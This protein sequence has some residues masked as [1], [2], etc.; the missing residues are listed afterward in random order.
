MGSPTPEITNAPAV[1][2]PE[3]GETSGKTMSPPGLTLMAGAPAAPPGGPDYNALAQQMKDELDEYFPDI[4]DVNAILEKVDWRNGWQQLSTAYNLVNPTKPLVL[5]MKERLSAANYNNAMERVTGISVENANGSVG[6]RTAEAGYNLRADA[7]ATSK[8]IG[9]MNFTAMNVKVRGKGIDGDTTFYKVVFNDTDYAAVTAGY[10]TAKLAPDLA[11]EKAAWVTG[12][13]LG[14]YVSWDALITQLEHFDIMTVGMDIKAKITML[15]QM[16]HGGDLPFDQVIGTSSGSYYEDDR[17][18][19]TSFYQLL[20]EG[21]AVKTP[22]GEVID[23]YHFI[24][25]LD[26]YQSARRRDKTPYSTAGGLLE[27]NP[28]IGASDAAATWAGDIG[29]GAADCL[30]SQSAEY[31]KY[32]TDN[33][34]GSESERIDYYYRSRAPESDLLGDIDAWGAYEE[35]DNGTAVTVTEVVRNY[36]GAQKAGGGA[37]KAKRKKSLDG[38]FARYGLKPVGGTYVTE[39]NLQ[40][41]FENIKRFAVIWLQMRTG[42]SF[43]FKN[44]DLNKFATYTTEMSMKFLL[45]IQAQYEKNK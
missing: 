29:A 7:K 43:A 17:P 26:A 23:I 24:V 1:A 20:K 12:D 18:N 27:M 8:Q 19:L 44:F 5:H 34:K 39:A 10:D 9:K 3:S 11:S 16:A 35:V 41:L 33:K 32:L 45:F 2:A 21:K 38:F 4:A 6:A 30:L 25:G 40:I 14:I 22:N 42:L 13:A 15:R 28:D 36:Y 31:E 37:F